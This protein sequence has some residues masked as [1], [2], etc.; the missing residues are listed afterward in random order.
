MNM[1]IKKIWL[2]IIICLIASISVEGF[3]LWRLVWQEKTIEET[4]VKQDV[5]G[6]ET[7]EPQP[8]KG[9]TA[10]EEIVKEETREGEELEEKKAEDRSTEGEE[11][12]R[13]ETSSS[14]K[15][16]PKKEEEKETVIP[17]E[18]HLSSRVESNYVRLEW[19]VGGDEGIGIESYNIYRTDSLEKSWETLGMTTT[20]KLPFRYIDWNPILG[21][22]YYCVKGVYEDGK[23]S[24][25]SNIVEIKVKI[26]AVE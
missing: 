16:V 3:I 5:Q 15:E 4:Q 8:E 20:F 10:G 21:R 17:F 2:I 6:E 23:E 19:F 24:K 9:Q 14:E 11:S 12:A 18:I 7:Y 13:K 26:E 25:S 22:S 1:K